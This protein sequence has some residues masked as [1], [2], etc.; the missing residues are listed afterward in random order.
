MNPFAAM[1][2]SS[3][4]DKSAWEYE[5]GLRNLYFKKCTYYIFCLIAKV[6]NI[7]FHFRAKISLEGRL[8]KR[9]WNYSKLF[10]FTNAF[11][12]HLIL[13]HVAISKIYKYKVSVYLSL[14]DIFNG[15]GAYLGLNLPIVKITVSSPILAYWVFNDC[16]IWAKASNHLKKET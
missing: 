16:F 12:F 6:I 11:L 9:F 10:F 1:K 13:I 14:Y 2:E 4:Q 5:A 15:L 8:G 3:W 7:L